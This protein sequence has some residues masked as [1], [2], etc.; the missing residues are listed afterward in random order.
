[1][2]LTRLA[3]VVAVAFVVPALTF[4]PAAAEDY[5]CEGFDESTGVSASTSP[6]V[7]YG[8]LGVERATELL[9]ERGIAP[10]EGVN[11]A[12]VDSGVSA[13]ENGVASLSVVGRESFGVDGPIVFE[14]GT[15]VA[16]LVAADERADGGPTGIAPAAG[17]VDLRVYQQANE[18][19]VGGVEPANVVA[20]L[21]WLV[22]N[23]EDQRIGVVVIALA[24]P[25]DPALERAIARLSK[26]DAVIVAGSGNRPT[27]E[28]QANFDD[29]GEL[30]P[31]EDA[32]GRIFPAA[33]ADDVFAVTATADGQ[34]V[35]AGAAADASGSVLLSSDIDAAVPTF[36]AVTL[37]TNGS[38]CVLYDVAT[39]WAAGIAGGVV[40]LLRSAY[41]DDN[42]AQIEARLIASASG[43]ATRVNT[44]TGH[45][46]LQPVEALTQ[47]HA[48]TRNGRVDDMPREASAHPR[49]TAPVA[50]PDPLTATLAAARW[51]GLFGG[52]AMVVALLAAEWRR[53]PMS[54]RHSDRVRPDTD[55]AGSS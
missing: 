26:Q 2:P 6:S 4:S 42:A 33:Y 15:N 17:I 53:C 39:S 55:P 14:H 52:A 32:A 36:G 37:A 23:A 24:M 38:T 3:T 19:G 43:S 34:R 11:V 50:E 8:L 40:A 25:P 46:V 48:P 21:D 31:G 28:G 29:F 44:A 54:A 1:M 13:P 49:V 9:A 12:V 30:K 18:T 22:A 5:D 27:E 7:P 45:G 51:W 10:G 41:P 16:G 35:A 47:E 20:A